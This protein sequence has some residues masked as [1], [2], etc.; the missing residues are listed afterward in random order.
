MSKFL[1]V[2]VSYHFIFKKSEKL[3]KIWDLGMSKQYCYEGRAGILKQ[4]LCGVRW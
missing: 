2:L 4:N 1:W 3:I